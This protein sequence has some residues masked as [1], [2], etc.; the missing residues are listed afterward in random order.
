[1]N[2]EPGMRVRCVD[3][4]SCGGLTNGTEYRVLEPRRDAPSALVRVTG[5]TLPATGATYYTNR[6]KPIVRVKAK[7]VRSIDLKIKAA[8]AWFAA[9]SPDQQAAHVEVQRQSWVRG[10]MGLSAV[11]LG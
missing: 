4:G 3:A 7:C 9:L 5:G 8:V 11:G 6:F 1:M 2:L 10:E